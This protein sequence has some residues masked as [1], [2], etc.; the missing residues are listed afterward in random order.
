MLKRPV[1]TILCALLLAAAFFSG[2]AR[3]FTLRY[4][5]GD[6]Y[7]PYSTLRADPL[8]A[9]AI[10]DAL[11]EMPGT[12]VRRNYRALPRLKPP[13]PVTLVYAGVA[14]YSVWM[15]KELAE[16]HNLVNGGTRAVF[17]F[18]PMDPTKNLAEQIRREEALAKKKAD[19]K[20]AK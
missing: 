14:R 1:L 2:V 11:A 4:E 20:M 6:V 17:A 19:E 9:K 12:S 7:P 15:E 18:K 5:H 3:L 8:G 16:F 13:Q 10:H